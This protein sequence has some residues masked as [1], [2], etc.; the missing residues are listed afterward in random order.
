MLK[1]LKKNYGSIPMEKMRELEKLI[2]KGE[3]DNKLTEGDKK[4]IY[5]FKSDSLKKIDTE[6]GFFVPQDFISDLGRSDLYINYNN[7]RVS[8]K[9][10]AA[11]K[12]VHQHFIDRNSRVMEILSVACCQSFFAEN[13]C[14]LKD[15]LPKKFFSSNRDQKCT[16]EVWIKDREDKSNSLISQ[17]V[18]MRGEVTYKISFVTDQGDRADVE[19]L[20]VKGTVDRAFFYQC[21]APGTHANLLQNDFE[22]S[23]IPDFGKNSLSFEIVE[24]DSLD[25]VSNRGRS[26]TQPA[27]PLKDR[28]WASETFKSS[29]YDTSHSVDEDD[30][31]PT[32]ES[33]SVVS[34]FEIEDEGSMPPIPK[35]I[36]SDTGF[37]KTDKETVSLPSVQSSKSSTK[38]SFFAR[39]RQ[40]WSDITETAVYYWQRIKS[41]FTF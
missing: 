5:K 39:I 2:E 23:Y 18:H 40:A 1:L 26:Q 29:E 31:F 37:I 4:L 7:K 35:I 24:N 12:R 11:F 17:Q 33:S 41:F 21:P 27:I 16:I 10:P 13:W 14:S 8:I 38:P 34:E 36:S 3:V 22:I 15:T 32:T 20:Q 6:K 28:H 19:H 25:S 30:T 9:N